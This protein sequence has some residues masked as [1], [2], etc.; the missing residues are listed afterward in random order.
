MEFKY[1]SIK[2]ILPMT[3][4]LAQL[5]EEAVELAKAGLKLRRAIDGTNPTPVTYEDARENLI[6]EYADVICCMNIILNLEDFEQIQNISERKMHRWK[7]RLFE[8]LA[9][10]EIFKETKEA[11]WGD[12]NSS[13]GTDDK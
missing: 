13:D 8:K 12:G 4:I 6:E 10:E 3:E 5:A 2:D 1:I 7:N 11:I 9:S